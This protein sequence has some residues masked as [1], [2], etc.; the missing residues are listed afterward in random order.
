MRAIFDKDGYLQSWI[1]GEN[2]GRFDDDREVILPDPEG[3]DVEAFRKESHLY[4]LVDGKL[5]KDENRQ[6]ELESQTAAEKKKLTRE[7]KLAL[8]IDALD[9]DEEPEQKKGVKH[10]P[11]FDKENMRF[12]WKQSKEEKA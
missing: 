3:L 2:M 1:I 12:S 8:F 11:F 10:K 9:V 4:R 6:K 5:V 7:E